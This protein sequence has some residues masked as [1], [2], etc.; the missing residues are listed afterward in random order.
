[1]L[2]FLIA[3]ATN[4][5]VLLVLIHKLNLN[6]GLSQV[7]AGIV[8]VATSFIM[9]KY[10][11]FKIISVAPQIKSD[12]IFNQFKS[13][14]LSMLKINSK[15]TLSNT[16]HIVAF[17]SISGLFLLLFWQALL[18][19]FYIVED[20]HLYDGHV[21]SLSDWIRRITIDIDGYQ[22]FRPGYW[23]YI[24]LGGKLFGTNP[25]LW[26]AAAL[27]W[28]VFT[29]YFFYIA[30]RKFGAD[31]ASSFIFVLL[32]VL[33]GNQNWIWFNLIPQ[34]TIGMLL[35]ALAVWSIAHASQRSQISRWD[36]LALTA[37]AVA[38][39]VKESFV[40]LIPALLLLRWTCQKRLDD[41]S[42]HETF[43]DSVLHS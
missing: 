38:G 25:H 2:V 22:R 39:F 1:M 11:V 26:H 16:E 6:E 4:F 36:V 28:G 19:N 21:T 41:E 18:A 43:S 13:F 32:L 40:L 23:L 42:W 14:A 24:I 34:E 30:L 29:C 27:S 35:T 7:L 15:L 5:L 10:Y 8:Y 17:V 37:M 31:I 9:N 33:S 12:A 20:H 3:Y